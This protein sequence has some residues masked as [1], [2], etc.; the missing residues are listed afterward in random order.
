MP[1]YVSVGSAAQILGVHPDTIR[2]WA[3][4]G[5]IQSKRFGGEGSHRRVDISN[6]PTSLC[7]DRRDY[8]Y[9]RV[10]TRAQRKHLVTQVDDL[11]RRYPDAVVVTDIGS[12]LNYKRPGLLKILAAALEGKVQ[13]VYV[14]HKD[15]LSRFSY[16]LI[17]FILNKSGSNIV[18][19]DDDK[20]HTHEGHELA[21]DIVSIITV[22]GA[23]L[24]GARSGASK[25]RR[26]HEAQ[27]AIG[28][29]ATELQDSDVPHDGT[30][31][32]TEEVVCSSPSSVQQGH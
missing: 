11:K 7:N 9:G 3:I 14:S 31:A 2:R 17:E 27:N 24:H 15:R 5:R 19:A 16:D 10:S 18:V 25:R 12:G 32:G 23:R 21:D 28:G 4:T 8:I 29:K 20:E 26:L 1:Q 6:I 30:E 13:T 22:F